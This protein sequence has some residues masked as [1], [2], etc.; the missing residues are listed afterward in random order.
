[1]FRSLECNQPKRIR[2]P[3]GMSPTQK[4][5][6]NPKGMSPTQ[7]DE[8][9]PKGMSPTQKDEENPKGM[10]PTQKECYQPKRNVTN[11]KGMLPKRM[12]TIKRNV[13]NQ[14][15]KGQ[16]KRNVTNPKVWIKIALAALLR[17]NM[18]KRKVYNC[19]IRT[20]VKFRI[21]RK[22]KICRR[23]RC[24]SKIYGILVFRCRRFN[25]RPGVAVTSTQAIFFLKGL[26][27]PNYKPLL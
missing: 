7:K 16:P 18:G 4:D 20:K 12:R 25:S 13:A 17:F 2:T 14:K 27:A 10:S 1:M 6:E 23:K 15:G 9:N 11:P 26:L 5:K 21:K 19:T 24:P 3:K 22:E 8:E